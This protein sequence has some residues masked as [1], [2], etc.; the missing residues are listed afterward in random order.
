MMRS[1]LIADGIIY[2]IVKLGVLAIVLLL[3]WIVHTRPAM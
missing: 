3:W 1:D 2:F